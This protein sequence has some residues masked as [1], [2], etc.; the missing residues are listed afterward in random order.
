MLQRSDDD[1]IPVNSLDKIPRFASE[2]EEHEF[3]STHS[4]GQPLLD[5]MKPVEDGSLPPPR[6]RTRRITTHVTNSTRLVPI[7]PL[8][9]RQLGRPREIELSRQPWL[10][11][12]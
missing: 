1:L 2:H 6:L 10:H 3:W 5:Q 12:S 4:L 8:M 11:A 9:R 7:Q